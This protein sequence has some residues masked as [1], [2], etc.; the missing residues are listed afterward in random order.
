MDKWIDVIDGQM[1]R[2][3]D[4][5]MEQMIDGIDDIQI[6][7]KS[8]KNKEECIYLMSSSRKRILNSIIPSRSTK[9]KL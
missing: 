6:N 7:K 2:Q 3:I 5:Q 8:Q 9:V 1:D 4:G